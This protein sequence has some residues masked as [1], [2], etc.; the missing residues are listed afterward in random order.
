MKKMVEWGYK[1]LE[2][3]KHIDEKSPIFQRAL[4]VVSDQ[5]LVIANRA[6][7]I[8][9][10]NMTAFKPVL[11]EGRSIEVP[12]IGISRNFGGDFDGDTFQ[13][14]TPISQKAIE[15]AKTM[16]PSASMLKTGYDTVL[17]SPQ[18]DMAVGAFLAS[19]GMGGEDTKIKFDNIEDAREA[20]KQNKFTYGDKVTVA[21][22]KATFGLH[23][24]NES[25]PDDMKKWDIELNQS[26]IDDW[27]KEVTKSHNGKIAV[28]LADKIK[29]VGNNYVTKFGFTLGL[30]DTVSD[31]DL[32]QKILKAAKGRGPVTA[33]SEL[34][35][36]AHNE[37]KRKHG[38][39][40]MLGIGIASGGSKGIA[41][42]AAITL[43]PGILTDS[44]DKPIPIPV[45]KSY[46]EGADTFG[47][48][49]AAHGA[50]SGNIKKSVSS[51]MPGWL[52]KDM[53]NS[54]Y[55]TKIVGEEPIDT[56]GVEYSVNDRKGIMNRFLARDIKDSNGKLIAKR[57]DIVDSSLINKMNQS[58]VKSVF[59]QSPLTDPTPGDGFS[60]Y[61]YGT[62]YEN[63]IHNRGD[64]IGIISAHTVTEPSLNMAMK[65]FHTGGAMTK[66]KGA[67]TVFDRLDKLLRFQ[68]TVPDKATLAS[69]DTIVRDVFKSPVGGWDVHFDDND[70]RYVESANTP[71][72][73]KGD[74]VKKG[75]QISTGKPSV[76]DIL[77]YKGMP[78]AQKF[79]VNELD[80]I[81]DKKLDKRDIETIVRGITNTTRIM[82]AGSSPFTP[83]DIAPTTTVE[84]YNNNNEKEENIENALGDHL[85]TNYGP[86][87]K[88]SKINK[89]MTT[90]L[91][92]KGI[93]RVSVF[94]DRIK[95][96]PFLVPL[97]IGG[98][99]ATS[100]DWISRLA[101]SRISDLLTQ[102]TTAG[103]KSEA[104]EIG[105]PLPKLVM[106][107]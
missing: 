34:I 85:A 14:H 93:K 44:A 84:Y 80:D 76:H 90:E 71:T 30:S 8:H 19:K 13:I 46:S 33:Y 18:M 9:R 36:E 25:V 41:N 99:A 10:W 15:E 102:G 24:I 83:G 107:M 59:V 75:Q 6:P 88:H 77:K 4:Q 12:A 86:Y 54:L 23:E 103:Y 79:L 104:N 1:P 50:R 7:T 82:N 106:G 101:H 53:I 62:D 45:T 40:T 61:S 16:L 29:S 96:S 56:V 26:N 91:S 27:I 39:S 37:L 5:R 65:A 55:E 60:A 69:A 68:R 78:E 11:T 100:E 70:V 43:M 98:K 105:S 92:Q 94:K 38:E 51:Y 47:Y 87:K 64:N 21:G 17:N 2:A 48:W 32:Q 22:K 57:S 74:I 63:K 66:G 67:A 95:H 58:K 20:F 73:K 31:K 89:S 81:N 72:V 3:T 42:S 28:G 52:T 49:A 97:G 35:P